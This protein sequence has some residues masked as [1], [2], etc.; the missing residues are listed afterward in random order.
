MGVGTTDDF[1]TWH[2]YCDLGD[3]LELDVAWSCGN[4]F[5]YGYGFDIDVYI[6][7][8]V[9]E[10]QEALPPTSQKAIEG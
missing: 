9:L 5:Y 1:Q 10:D 7:G 6:L 4:P 2:I 3:I 8:E